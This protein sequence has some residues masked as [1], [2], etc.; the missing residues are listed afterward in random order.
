MSDAPDL[1]P[2]ALPRE[3]WPAHM[4][5]PGAPGAGPAPPVLPAAGGGSGPS[6]HPVA[7][8]LARLSAGSRKSVRL[9]LRTMARLL[10]GAE[11]AEM[12]CPWWRLTYAETAALR[13]ALADRYKP[14]TANK[15]LAYLRS[16]LRECWRLG[17]GDRGEL[18]RAAALDP[19][20]GSSL[21]PGRA[22]EH[23]EITALLAAAGLRDG[24][25]IALLAG[26][27]L[28][29]IEAVRLTWAD[30]DREDNALLVHGK[31]NKERL[32]HLPSTVEQRLDMWF[33]VCGMPD[34]PSATVFGVG[35]RRIGELCTALAKSAGAKHFT[36]H[37]LR[38]TWITRLLERGV[39]VLTVQA[40]AGHADPRTTARYDRRGESAKRAA[41]AGV[42]L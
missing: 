37:D 4:G 19:V 14:A 1:P 30:W 9:G 10:T 23:A 6:R 33:L 40:M 41:A 27:G 17:L 15:L 31:G 28:R 12:Q 11:R 7:V 24:A 39:D 5:S 16:V 29:A 22:L 36:P 13:A 42:T 18:E 26:C 35:E 20:R 38:R 8:Y 34:D 21:P 25:L 2:V 3:G 32:A